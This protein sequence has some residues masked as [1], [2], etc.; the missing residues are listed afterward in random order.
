MTTRDKGITLPSGLYFNVKQA[1]YNA[2]GDGTT[3]DTAAIQAAI[4]AARDAGK[5][6]VFPS[7]NYRITSSLVTQYDGNYK[8]TDWLSLG[9][10]II[11]DFVGSSAIVVR[12]GSLIQRLKNFTIYPSAIYASNSG[13]LDAASHGIEII[14]SVVDLSA[15]VYNFRGNGI[16]IEST[17][18]NSNTSKFDCNVQTCNRGVYLFGTNDN[19]SVVQAS[20]RIYNC[21]RSAFYGAVGC[22][23]RQWFGWIYAEDNCTFDTSVAAVYM[24]KAVSSTWWIYCEQLNAANEIDLSSAN[25]QYNFIT[26]ARYNKDTYANSNMVMYGGEVRKSNVQLWTPVIQGSTT[27]GTQTYSAQKGYWIREGSKISVWGTITLT[28]KDAA[29]AGNLRIGGLPIAPAASYTGMIFPCSL[30]EIDFLSLSASKISHS[31]VFSLG[32]TYISLIETA[33][34]AAATNLPAGNLQA[35][36]TITFSGSYLV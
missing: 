5:Q 30:G 20:F 7:G 23:I 27:P 36:T 18:L 21:F 33:S 17:A 25:N 6:L 3:D 2:K 32:N 9:A 29:T 1:P 19:I 8:S 15:F 12:G 14:N 35:T 10:N 11:A 16:Q 34:N 4:N 31:A 28:A 26:S 24:E 13:N 22:Q